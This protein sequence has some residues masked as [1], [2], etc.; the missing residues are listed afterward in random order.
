MPNLP[1]HNETLAGLSPFAV[2]E[3]YWE[4]LLDEN[5]RSSTGTVPNSNGNGFHGEHNQTMPGEQ[6]DTPNPLVQSDWELAESTRAQD[7]VLELTAVGYNRGGLLVRWNSIQGFVPASQL[8][9]FPIEKNDTVRR[10]A[11]SQRIGERLSL[12]II[13]LNIPGRRL[14]LSERAALTSPGQRNSMLHTLAPG[15]TQK[16]VITNLCD[17]GAFA[18]LGGV[19][20]LIHISEISWGRVNHPADFLTIG[21]EVSVHIIGIEPQAERIALS[22]K[23]LQPDPWA[24]VESRYQV[25]QIIPVTISNVVDFGAFASVEKGLEGL[26]HI[27]EL[28]E[29]Q[30]LHPNN[31]ISEGDRV[32]ARILLIDGKARRLG[33]SLRNLT[34]NALSS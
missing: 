25:G 26:I 18:D 12:R 34:E 29:G 2:D 30:F 27:S 14:I 10:E 17:F 5:G 32:Q 6:T 22:L 19:E 11:L 13:E 7:Q 24:S 16:A 1:P 9:N 28:A 23:R 4:S 8:L 20:G 31:V 21:Q 3:S 15:S 33:L